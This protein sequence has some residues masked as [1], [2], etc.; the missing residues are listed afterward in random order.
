MRI[1]HVCLSNFFIDDRA[2]QE[3]E[4]VAAHARAGHDV[5]VVAS[6]HVHGADGRRDFTE[7]GDYRT[8]EGARVIR[9]PY[10][11]ALPHGLAK[12]LRVH[13][14]VYGLLSEFGPDAIM[15][16]GMCG[17]ELLTAARYRRDHP[18]VPLFV[19]NH[20][21]FVNS[22]RGLVSKWG[23]HFMYY[24]PILH[25]VLP[26]VE[27]VLC[28]STLTETFARDFYKVPNDKLEFYPLGG[29]PVP[30]DALEAR[31]AE[32]RAREGIGDDDLMFIQSGKQSARKYL[33]EMLRAFARVP[34]RR[35]R[36]LI[37]GMLMND[38]KEDVEILIADD[39]RVSFIGWKSPD[40]LEDLLCAADVY[41]QPGSQSSS[42][43]TSLCCGC[44]VVL[45]ALPGHE[46]YVSDNGW[47]IKSQSQLETIFRDISERKYSIE[48][49]R[50]K[51]LAF[52]RKYLDYEKLAMRI[53]PKCNM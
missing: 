34:D 35:F 51:S 27:K 12:S 45:E 14:G 9:L 52:A 38:I 33:P 10:H 5:L 26:C 43:Q 20:A 29:H 30:D 2:Y 39:P 11:P 7:P 18:T 46:R 49:M 3:N 40:E 36:L 15:F 48:E 41:L 53:V 8:E 17:W 16:H 23:L 47:L 32:T 22:A 50:R 4:L 13:C 28:I 37:A 42:M 25:R 44:A 21:D 6:T 19:D 24:R 1:A 31:R